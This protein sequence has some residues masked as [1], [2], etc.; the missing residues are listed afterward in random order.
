M[1]LR[2]LRRARMLCVCALTT[3]KAGAFTH[4]SRPQAVSG[5]Q[6]YRFECAALRGE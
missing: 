4:Q 5:R 3:R 1:F 6:P 2:G